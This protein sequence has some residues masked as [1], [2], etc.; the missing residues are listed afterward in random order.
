MS[1]MIILKTNGDRRESVF[2]EIYSGQNG[3]RKQLQEIVGGDIEFVT[4]LYNDQRTTMVVN[5][6][7]AI[8]NPPLP[9]NKEASHIY[10]TAQSRRDGITLDVAFREYPRIHGDVAILDGVK[11]L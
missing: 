5:E 9:V 2:P 8:Q 10:H 1:K 7:G 4:V 11:V 6:T 3:L